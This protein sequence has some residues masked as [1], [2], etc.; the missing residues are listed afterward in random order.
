MSPSPAMKPPGLGEPVPWFKA[1]CLDGRSN[2]AFDTVAGRH[3]LMLFMG[4]ADPEARV[5][6]ITQVHAARS[7]FDDRTA[8]FFGVSSDPE[9]VAARI[10]TMLPGIRYF[11]DHDLAVS[12]AYGAEAD[13]FWLIVDPSLRALARYPIEQGGKAIAALRAAGTMLMEDSWAP[14]LLVPNILE[15][16]LCRRLVQLHQDHGGEESGF[17]REID[18][19]TVLQVDPRHKRRRDWGIEDPALCR[20]LRVRVQRRLLPMVERAFQFRPTRIERYIVGCYD[21]SDGGHFRPHRDNTTAGTAHRRFAVTIN[22]NADQYDGGDLRFPEYGSRTYRAPTGGAVV[23]SCSLLHE[24]T[25]V[26]RGAR[27]AF[28]PFLYDEEA[29]QIRKSNNSRLGENVARYRAE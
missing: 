16:T 23:F 5:R 4:A 11:L 22:L 15:P 1:H 26:T 20:Q 8:C 21:A 27:Y 13:A 19:T 25:P 2:Y 18:G 3:I 24:A 6:A 9:D 12:R 29:A 14:V 7:M 28:L 10:A 17:M